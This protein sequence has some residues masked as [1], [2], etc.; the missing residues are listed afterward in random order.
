MEKCVNCVQNRERNFKHNAFSREC[1]A[2][3]KAKAFVIR[4][5]DLNGEKND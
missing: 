5:T 3:V 1:P 4:K 2:V